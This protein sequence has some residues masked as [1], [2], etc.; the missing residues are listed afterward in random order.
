M[1]PTGGSLIG[2]NEPNSVW[3]M[4]STC[5]L[6]ALKIPALTARLIYTPIGRGEILSDIS[7]RYI[8]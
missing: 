1:S 6:I 8:S 7:S 4:S 3:L 2:E 5:L